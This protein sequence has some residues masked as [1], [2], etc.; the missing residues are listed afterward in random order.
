MKKILLIL[1][2]I[3]LFLSIFFLNSFFKNNNDFNENN[4]ENI[5]YDINN[6][7]FP[8]IVELNYE[9]SEKFIRW[10]S[11][12]VISVLKGDMKLPTNEND[13]S[14]L[15]RYAYKEAL[16]KHDFNWAQSSGFKGNLL[17]DIKKYNYPYVPYL[18]TNI[19]KNKAG[20][21]NVENFGVYASARYLIEEN[22][23]FVSKDKS[24]ARTGDIVAFL[25][26][27]D[28]EFPYHLMVYFNELGKEYVVYH[29]GPLDINNPGVMRSVLVSELFRA[30]PSWMIDLKNKNF[31]GF[32]RFKILSN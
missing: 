15:V 23:N 13:C 19:F 2:L 20:N 12:I 11:S 9:D 14:G 18:K 7:G 22:M 6:N 32:Y 10:F 1:L 16:K 8:D 27:D 31:L 3:I 29:T 5:V 25:H 30:D 17:E 24:K 26:F 4:T 21:Y 28:P